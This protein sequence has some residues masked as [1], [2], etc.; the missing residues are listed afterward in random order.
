MCGA[1]HDES[2]LTFSITVIIGISITVIYLIRA[3]PPLLPT[4]PEGDRG[5]VKSTGP[6]A[7][8]RHHAARPGAVSVPFHRACPT[9]RFFK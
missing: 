1:D 8:R 2:H 3:P 4:G 9:G 5:A 7:L 6:A